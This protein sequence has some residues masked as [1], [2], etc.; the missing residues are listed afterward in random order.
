M[1]YGGIITSLKVPD[2]YGEPGEVVLGHS[3][4]EP[5]L[6][7]APYLG[8]IVGRYVLRNRDCSSMMATCSVARQQASTA[9]CSIAMRACVSRPSTIPTRRLTRIFLPLNSGP[10][11]GIARRR[12]GSS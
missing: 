3:S 11:N 5:Y 8:D 7:N 2:R 1:T 6:R 4:I 10:T 12:G 9:A